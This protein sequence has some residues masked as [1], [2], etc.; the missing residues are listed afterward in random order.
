MLLKMAMKTITMKSLVLHSVWRKKTHSLEHP[1]EDQERM[2]M[3]MRWAAANDSHGGTSETLKLLAD[4]PISKQKKTLLLRMGLMGKSDI[5]RRRTYFMKDRGRG[6][7]RTSVKMDGAAN[8]SG[9]WLTPIMMT[10]TD[11]SVTPQLQT[12][13][14]AHSFKDVIPCLYTNNISM[15][16]MDIKEATCKI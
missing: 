8:N 12:C 16:I 6:Q 10:D 9:A 5:L 13:G 11:N 7:G 14:R 4:T 2:M 1:E 3:K 15:H